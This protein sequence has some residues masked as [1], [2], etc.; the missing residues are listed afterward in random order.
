MGKPGQRASFDANAFEDRW[1]S[2]GD[3]FERDTPIE[4]GI[5]GRPYFA[6]AAT[7]NACEHLIT[8]NFNGSVD[9]KERL[10]NFGPR[11]T[12]AEPLA[13]DNIAKPR[14][15]P[16]VKRRVIWVRS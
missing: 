2:G 6:A 11:H 14:Y 5:K 10:C 15:W 13:A 1:I 9:P 4:L 16:T 7:A 3:H 12:S 8:T